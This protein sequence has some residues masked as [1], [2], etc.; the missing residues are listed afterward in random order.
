MNKR[1]WLRLHNAQCTCNLC[2]SPCHKIEYFRQCHNFF[3]Q[4]VLITCM[5]M[6]KFKLGKLTYDGICVVFQTV[7]TDFVDF[8]RS[9]HQQSSF[10]LKKH[11][12]F[13]S[14]IFEQIYF[15]FEFSIPDQCVM[16]S[17]EAG[18]IVVVKTT[19]I[20][21][22]FFVIRQQGFLLDKI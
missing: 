4:F 5:L 1:I 12:S 6:I 16:C 9:L 7:L 17:G 13:N 15:R 21:L 14:D 22:S 8:P 3:F 11:F 19:S 18:C 2:I 10:G 20:S